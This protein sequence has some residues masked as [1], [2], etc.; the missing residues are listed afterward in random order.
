MADE[1]AQGTQEQTESLIDEAIR[2]KL[3]EAAG[4]SESAA[5]GKASATTLLE[6][7]AIAST[8][9]NPKISVLERLLLADAIGS[10]MADA[11]APALA[12]QLVPRLL[13]FQEDGLTSQSGKGTSR[14]SSTSGS[15]GPSA[16][17]RRSDSATKPT[18][19]K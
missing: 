3:S 2:A 18:E 17:S 8:L 19:P 14:S 5:Q 1:A 16:T 10:A 4:S 9:S 6:T 15:A 12:E 7:V 11:L 13:K